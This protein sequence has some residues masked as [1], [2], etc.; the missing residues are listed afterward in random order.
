M[1]VILKISSSAPRSASWTIHPNFTLLFWL[2]MKRVNYCRRSRRTQRGSRPA[3]SL[4][5]PRI[6]CERGGATEVLQRDSSRS[7]EKRESGGLHSAT[8][9][10]RTRSD[11]LLNLYSDS[12]NVQSEHGSALPISLV[13]TAHLDIRFDSIRPSSFRLVCFVGRGSVRMQHSPLTFSSLLGFRV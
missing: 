1:E 3:S 12:G 4:P 2:L 10:L 7:G 5:L 6:C 11:L 8:I 13:V 9:Y